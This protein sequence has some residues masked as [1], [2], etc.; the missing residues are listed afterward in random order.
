MSSFFQGDVVKRC[1]GEPLLRGSSRE[2]SQFFYR[3]K[4]R[5]RNNFPSLKVDIME[6]KVPLVFFEM[7]RYRHHE[8][9]R[10]C[11]INPETERVCCRLRS[12][13]SIGSLWWHPKLH[14]HFGQ[15]LMTGSYFQSFFW[16]SKEM[17]HSPRGNL[18]K[19]LHMRLNPQKKGIPF[20][21][22]M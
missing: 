16:V 9:L 21:K 10:S 4:K 7:S 20:S 5:I 8:I 13:M 6:P 22:G 19:W 17:S 11:R 1:M 14:V 3:C 12:E 2:M 18:F 15:P